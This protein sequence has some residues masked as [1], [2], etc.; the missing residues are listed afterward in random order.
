MLQTHNLSKTFGSKVAVENLNISVEVGQ[1]RGLLGP[2]GAGKST[3]IRMI[4][5]VLAPTCGTVTIDGFDI[6]MNPTS[7]KKLLGYVPEG[8]P[9]PHELLPIEFLKYT[10][11]L[12]GISGNERKSAISLWADRCDISDVLRKPIGTLSRGYRQRVA[13][14]AALVHKPRLIVLDEPSTGLDPEQ[15]ASFRLLLKELSEHAA[16]IYSSHHLSDVE[17][18]CDVVTI[19]NRGVGILDGDLSDL[20]SES[21]ELLV[22]VSPSTIA[23]QIDGTGITQLEG[24]WVRCFVNGDASQ[25]A[26]SVLE[27]GG[28]IRL[29][30]PVT[31]SIETNYLRIIH[32][33]EVK[34]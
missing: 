11:S 30:K 21:T 15:N 23:N 31:D 20:C 16:I 26:S 10:A 19:I 13:L 32:S 18:T 17:A 9:L 34:S 27:A 22:E 7:A 28:Q 33:S 4:C 1:V 25:V 12:F 8:A 2:N 3:A 6:S 24:N 29:I 5:G 14:A